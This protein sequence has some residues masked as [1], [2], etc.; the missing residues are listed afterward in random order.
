MK[1][2]IIF[3]FHNIVATNISHTFCTLYFV[4]LSNNCIKDIIIPD[5]SFTEQNDLNPVQNYSSRIV[6]NKNEH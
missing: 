6:K 5:K 4:Q 1:L 2:I 3:L